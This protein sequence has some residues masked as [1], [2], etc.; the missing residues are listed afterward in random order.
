M[1]E[2]VENCRSKTY[3][4]YQ[5]QWMIAHHHSIDEMVQLIG[6]IAWEEL[7]TNS[8]FSYD[9]LV[10]EAY[11][12]FREERG[13]NGEIWVCKNEFNDMEKEEE[14]ENEK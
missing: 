3:E 8:A 12:I 2:N 9:K 14:L 6:K 11:Q 13:F 1:I 10:D 5:L 7:S 4:E